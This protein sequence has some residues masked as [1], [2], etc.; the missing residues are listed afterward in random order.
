MDALLRS[1][2]RSFNGFAA[3]LTNQEQKLAKLSDLRQQDHETSWAQRENP[4]AGSDAV[5]GVLDSGIW[6]GSESFCGQAQYHK[7][8]LRTYDLVIRAC[9]CTTIPTVDSARDTTGH[10]THTASIAAGN[11]V[12]DASF[13]G[14]ANGIATKGILTVQ[15][16]RNNGLI[17]PETITSF[18]AMAAD[19]K[20][21]LGN[22]KIIVDKAVNSNMN[23]TQFPF[24]Y[25]KGVQADV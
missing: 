8:K 13:Y 3:H 18:C 10:G 14:I 11:Y 22:G 1:Y 4:K 23:G 20:V 12:E 24:V 2:K 21:T 15:S 16:A 5:I 25:G 19:T 6:P 17:R 7:L 9:F